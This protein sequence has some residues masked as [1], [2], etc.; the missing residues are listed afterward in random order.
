MD[1]L[2]AAT[3]A[4][5]SIRRSGAFGLAGVVAFLTTGA[6][7][8]FLRADLDWERAPLSFYLLGDFS[9]WVQ[10]G[11]FALAVALT[12]LG[13]GF[14]RVLQPGARSAAP[15]LLFVCSALALCVTAIADSN[16]PQ[17][18]PTLQGL[19]HG[20]AAQ[21]AF[22]CVTT[23]MLLQSWRFRSDADWHRR[24]NPAFVLAAVSFGALWVHALWRAAPRGLTQKGVIL[25]ILGWLALA[26]WWLC[27][28]RRAGSGNT[29]SAGAP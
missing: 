10:A 5:A 1:N 22:L 8:Q 28:S 19:V 24:F 12:V 20:I 4:D 7:A 17:R 2:P 26:S 21:A 3:T 18:T 14:Y 6:A 9:G 16:L 13:I 23:A 11:Y 15:L 25:L 27:R 29:G